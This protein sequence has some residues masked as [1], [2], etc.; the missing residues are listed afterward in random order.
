[1][2]VRIAKRSVPMR[3]IDQIYINGAFVTPHGQERAPLFNPSTE[4]QVGT[5]RL[6]NAEDV[7]AA[8]AAAK[9]AFPA[10]SRTSKAERIA[11]LDRLSAAVSERAAELTAVMAEE[12][13][14]PAYFTGFSV[15]HAASVLLVLATA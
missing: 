1:M 3:D 15:A 5:V 11:M 13:G 10:F 12:Y 8:V 4:E 9:R 14:A 2:G 7:D 6:G